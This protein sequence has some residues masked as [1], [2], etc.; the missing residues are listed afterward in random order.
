MALEGT[1]LERCPHA[2]G[3]G[4]EVVGNRAATIIV[5]PTPVGMDR[6]RWV[7][8]NGWPS[9]PHA[10][11]EG[12]ALPYLSSGRVLFA[13]QLLIFCIGTSAG[14]TPLQEAA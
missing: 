6:L 12:D 2:C 3:D 7:R 8:G 9:C 10:C 14:Y 11:G 1:N 4:P 13:P 5:V